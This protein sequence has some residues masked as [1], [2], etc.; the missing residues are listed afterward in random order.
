MPAERRLRQAAASPGPAMYV[1]GVD[2]GTQSLK[3]LVADVGLRV[4]GT[5]SVAYQPS[6]PRP[7]WAEQDPTLWL[8]A[9][10]PAIAGALA[11][12]GLEF[13]D[14]AALGVTGQLD[15]CVPTDAD[16]EP[17]GPCLIWMD[18]RSEPQIA[19]L[20]RSLILERGGVVA[21][22]THMGAKAAWLKAQGGPAAAC[23]HQPV[24]FLVARLT[25]RAVLD[26]ALASTTML[27]DLHRRAFDP[28]L[29]ALFGVA[30]DELPALADAA[31]PAGPLTAAGARLTGLT[32]GIPVAVGTGDDFANLLGV[33]MTTPGCV[34]CTLG[35][36]EVVG[37]LAEAPVVD[38]QGLV[39]THPFP[40]GGFLLENPGW[41]S[42]GALEWF[43]RVFGLGKVAELDARAA[44]APPGSDGVLFLPALS[45]AMTPEW[46]GTAR[47]AFY[48]LTAA[49]DTGHLA[50]AT[51]EG[52]A[53]AMRDVVERL[54]DLG[55]ATGR[56]LL[57]GGAARS[58]LWAQ[59]RADVA[60]RPVDVAEVIDAAPLGAA[61]LATVAAGAHADIP[62]ASAALAGA[63]ASIAPDPASAP[64]YAR[65]YDA[66]RRL[67]N[68]LRPMF[69]EGDA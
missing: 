10:A 27:Y 18:R 20:P 16:N 12:A 19:K 61:V 30:E 56:V 2:V 37:A 14:V 3:A 49:H 51:L 59:I 65:A 13:G 32:E 31:A 5:A 66:Y 21:D 4:H 39:E 24:S 34:V 60:G 46:I 48:G 33:G 64:A 45:G 67:F 1:C 54:A 50:R 6:F 40:G 53:F 25:G 47:G 69:N 58:R 9:L 26:H 35:T 57:V 62:A 11:Q 52:C 23:F 29:L 68:S 41:L 42:G 22:S 17:L 7:L 43:V 8:Q 44:E 15:G 38:R 55:V 63:N 36:A 28:D